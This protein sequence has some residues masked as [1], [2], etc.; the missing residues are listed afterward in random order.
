MKISTSRATYEAFS[1]LF[2]GPS[3]LV[4][5]SFFVIVIPGLTLTSKA[6]LNDRV[7]SSWLGFLTQSCFVEEACPC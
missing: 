5:S 7:T 6:D 1:D 3:G 4:Y 2:N